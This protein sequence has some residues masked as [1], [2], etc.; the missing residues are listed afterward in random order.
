MIRKPLG[1]LL[2]GTVLLSAAALNAGGWA[3]VTLDALP[4]RV[5][6]GRPVPL[7]FMVRQHGTNPLAGLKPWIEASAGGSRVSS[8]ATAATVTGRY[9]ATL[10]L[11]RADDW[12]ITIHS[13]F[14]GSKLTLL[15]LTVVEAGSGSQAAVSG[16]EKG[17]RL[18]VAK[19]CVTCHVHDVTTSNDSLKVGPALVPKKYQDEFLARVLENPAATLPRSQLPVGQM[20]NLNL[21]PQEISALVAFINHGGSK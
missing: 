20:P 19:G 13:G 14:G 4:D 17:R 21:Q 10:T 1:F 12:S 15:P 11:P 16:T 3:V 7:T 9:T 2:S 18:F 5:E 8:D 6:A